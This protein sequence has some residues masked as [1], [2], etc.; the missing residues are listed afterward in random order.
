MILI[1]TLTVNFSIKIKQIKVRLYTILIEEE[2]VVST[3]INSVYTIINEVD[4]N[5]RI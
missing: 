4:I 3:E 5:R 2:S 1:N